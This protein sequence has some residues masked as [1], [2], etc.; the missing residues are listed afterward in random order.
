MNKVKCIDGVVIKPLKRIDDER[1]WLTEILRCDDPQ[2]SQFGQV[3]MTAVYRD[4]IKGLH[5]HGRQTDHVTCVHGR[6][7]VILAKAAIHEDWVTSSCSWRGE[8][9][10]LYL[11]ADSP[12][13]VVIPP[14]IYHGWKAYECDYALMI[15]VPN[16]PYDRAEPDEHRLDPY[17]LGELW[18]RRDG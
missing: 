18:S 4:V 15:N 14:G 2:F 10:E 6:V 16:L 1:G 5:M 12:S 13:L 8:Y 11:T 17:E 3:Y 9:M 7:K